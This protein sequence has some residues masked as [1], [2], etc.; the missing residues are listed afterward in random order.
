MKENIREK[1][2]IMEKQLQE[3]TSKL[4]DKEI[5]KASKEEKEEYLKMLAEIKAKIEILKSYN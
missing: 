5:L 2:E 3:L 1:C 4:S